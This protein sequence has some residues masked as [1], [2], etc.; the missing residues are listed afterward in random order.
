M[1]SP[2]LRGISPTRKRGKSG[3]NPALSRSCDRIGL[4]A[5]VRS[6]NARRLLLPKPWRGPG[7][8]MF[9]RLL[10][11]AALLLP[12]AAGP[13][14]AHHPMESM[15]LVPTPL[16]GLISGLA[17]PLLGPD[18]LLFLLALALVGLQQ[19]RRW[20][21]GL[22]AVGLAGSATGVALPGLP[23]A[24]LLVALS[25][26]V[27]GLV[28]AGAAPRSLLLP[29][30]ALHGYVLSAS[31]IGWEATPIAGYFLGLLISQGVLL[32]LALGVL[33]SAAARL[34]LPQLRLLAGGLIGVGAAFSWSALVG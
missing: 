11:A 14:L 5:C 3:V 24:E 30:F 33:R 17:H 7:D 28:V 23:Q 32:L 16:T 34:P 22:L 2:V 10:P 27:E 4:L 8:D 13:A 15:G 29:A 26:V 19:S 20:T 1:I 6:Q 18:H 9:K 21:L 31:V 25:L 12:I